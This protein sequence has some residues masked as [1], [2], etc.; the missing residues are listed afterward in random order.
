MD[1]LSGSEK[2]EPLNV[3]GALFT[4]SSEG[5]GVPCVVFTGGEE[6]GVRIYSDEL[7]KSLRFV[8]ADSSGI[9]EEDVKSVTL[10]MIIDDI[11]KVRSSLGVEK[12]AVMGHSRF[13]VIPPAYGIKYPEHASHLIVTGGLPSISEKSD[14]ASSE[15][16]ENEASEERKELYKRNTEALT[17]DVM[18]TLSP[19]EAFIKMY[20]ASTPFLFCDTE[21]DMTGLWEGVEFDADFSDHFLE[22]VHGIDKTDKYHLIQAPVIAFSG[23][24]DF[25]APYH[26]WGD[27]RES[28]PDFT[29]VLFDN[30]GHNPMLEIPAEFDK[31]LIDWIESH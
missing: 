15:Y 4:Y 21:Y 28:I 20:T 25:W 3:E 1:Q 10:D 26:L 6:I 18:S 22:I 2:L 13:S 7:K 9:S 17:D 27:V 11:E 31:K 14:K 24:Y 23:R 30:A 5:T 8:H 12:I 16:W 19:G 29:F